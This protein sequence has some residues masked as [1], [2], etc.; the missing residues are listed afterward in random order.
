MTDEEFQRLVL[1]EFKALRREQQVQ[2]VQANSVKEEF[3]SIHKELVATRQEMR[4][5]FD[6]S[7]KRLEQ[8]EARLDQMEARSDQSDKRLEQMEV[9]LDQSDKR[10]ER[11]E[12]HREKTEQVSLTV[13]HD[14]VCDIEDT[15]SS[16]SGVLG[17]HELRL[18]KLVRRLV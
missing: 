6:Q 13:I 7:D 9:R 12:R 8:M 5:R 4:E 15:L 3:E 11:L 14:K 2:Q 16:V 1:N 18:R 17:D 10:F